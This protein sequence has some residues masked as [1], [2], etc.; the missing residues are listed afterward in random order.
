MRF[1]CRIGWHDWGKWSEYLWK[2]EIR[3]NRWGIPVTEW[4]PY[5]INVFRRECASC[6]KIEQDPEEIG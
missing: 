3:R 4:E 6:G 5:Q 1:L 2:G